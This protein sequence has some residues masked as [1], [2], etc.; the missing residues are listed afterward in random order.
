MHLGKD[1]CLLKR[2][3][4]LSICRLSF[5]LFLREIYMEKV[6]QELFW[7]HFFGRPY[8]SNGTKIHLDAALLAVF[9]A[10]FLKYV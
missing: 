9:S 3:L 7:A 2:F 8:R 4:F 1:I 5:I 10:R 6:L